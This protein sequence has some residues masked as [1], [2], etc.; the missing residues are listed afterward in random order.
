MFKIKKTYTLI[1][2]II[3]L[4]L[5]FSYLLFY[6]PLTTTVQSKLTEEER[7]WIKNNPVVTIGFDPAYAPFEFYERGEFI[8]LSV[9]YLNWIESQLDIKFKKVY[10]DT[11]DDLLN[12]AYEQ[13]IDLTGSIIKNDA[14]VGKILFTEPF[15][16]NY[17]IILVRKDHKGIKKDDIDKVRTAVIKNY[18]VAD[19]IKEKYPGIKL[20]EV[21]DIKDGLKLLSFGEVD[22]FVTD[23]SQGIYYIEKYGYQNIY[24]L[25]DSKLLSDGN[26]R[27][28]IRKDAPILESIMNKSISSMPISF[29]NEIK[30]KW[31]GVKIDTP[32]TRANLTIILIALAILLSLVIIVVLINRILKKEINAK[33]K[34]IRDELEHIKHIEEELKLLNS[35]LEEKVKERTVELENVIDNLNKTRAQMI[36]SEKMASLGGLVAGV[37]HEI[38]TPLGI[39]L[40]AST[41][42][43]LLIRQF[44]ERM[45]DKKINREDMETFL[46]S[47]S[48]GTEMI[49]TN[50]HKASQLVTSF[51]QLAIDQNTDDKKIFFLRENCEI[52]V[53][54]LKHELEHKKISLINE[55]PAYLS[56]D[57]YP[58]AFS[59][60]FTHLILN[61]FQHAFNTSQE[62]III[63]EG[64]S[65]DEKTVISCIDNGDG[66]PESI[67]ETMFEPFVTTKRYLG[68]TGLGLHIVYNLVYHKLRGNILVSSNE[69]NGTKI[70][71]IIPKYKEQSS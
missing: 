12:A 53:T 71:I 25:E 62:G 60:I 57:S 16:E 9:D 61:S 28:G 3:A 10:F 46:S 1:S 63:I 32:I 13:K 70:Q 11:W 23:F 18:A 21:K 35:T 36:E 14:R 8:G 26:L 52:V 34:T 54:S 27:Y 6:V 45:N 69:K 68:N 39:T 33:T 30:A 65:D 67:Q 50:L 40:T 47:I 49:N 66:I 56:I 22:A 15:F 2:L 4:I 48:Q 37:A 24:A 44:T 7:Q 64:Y 43:D 42:I 38:N 5:Y 51:K 59:Q 41:Y 19:F 55:I 17:D 58:G 20:I 31:L 29:K